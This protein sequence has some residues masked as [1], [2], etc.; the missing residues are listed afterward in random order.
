MTIASYTDKCSSCG[1]SYPPVF[2]PV[3]VMHE[4]GSPRIYDDEFWCVECVRSKGED[5]PKDE[6]TPSRKK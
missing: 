2:F 4:H 5:K 3:K 6:R 1:K